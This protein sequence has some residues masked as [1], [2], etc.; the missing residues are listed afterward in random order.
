MKRGGSKIHESR[1][2]RERNLKSRRWKPFANGVSVP[3]R[4][5][6]N[7]SARTFVC[8]C[9]SGSQ[10]AKS[11]LENR[12]DDETTNHRELRSEAF[13]APK[14]ARSRRRQSVRRFHM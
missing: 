12:D 13:L 6:A 1:T 9:G 5:M 4:R 14:S 8:R 11:E 2:P 7:R 3:G 10:L